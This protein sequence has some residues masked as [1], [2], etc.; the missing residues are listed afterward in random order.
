MHNIE[1]FIYSSFFNLFFNL[2]Y[3]H[4]ALFSFSYLPKP[5]IIHV[6]AYLMSSYRY[7][8]MF[9][10]SF[11]IFSNCIITLEIVW[12]IRKMLLFFL[13]TG[14]WLILTGFVLFLSVVWLCSSCRIS[15]VLFYDF[16]PFYLFN[17]WLCTISLISAVCSILL[18]WLLTS[19]IVLSWCL[20]I[21]EVKTTSFLWRLLSATKAPF[22]L[23]PCWPYGVV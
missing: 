8:M 19:P 22:L 13:L 9:H 1:I 11:F 5:P 3:N 10:F 16:F 7:I 17:F 21:S 4:S 2:K 23:A 6:S 14:F 15:M 12:N 20:C 18:A